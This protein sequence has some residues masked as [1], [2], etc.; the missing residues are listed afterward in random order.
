[1]NNEL[2]NQGYTTYY[3]GSP[4][5]IIKSEKIYLVKDISEISLTNL[6]Q[7][8]LEILRDPNNFSVPNYL[9]EENC[10]FLDTTGG[11]VIDS[12]NT[13]IYL[14]SDGPTGYTKFY[15][16]QYIK[17]IFKENE[18]YYVNSIKIITKFKFTK[19]KHK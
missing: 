5:D 14:N 8:F 16:D 2:S 6:Y 7:K 9:E 1:M 15:D 4:E 19:N 13:I 18:V 17:C 11:D 3:S 12:F 10:F